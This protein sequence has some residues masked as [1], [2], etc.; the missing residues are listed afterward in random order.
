MLSENPDGLTWRM[1]KILKKAGVAPPE[2]GVDYGKRLKKPSLQGFHALKTSFVTLSLNAGISMEIVQKVVGNTVVEVVREHYF[3]P[4]K[5]SI[6][7]EFQARFPAFLSPRADIDPAALIQS[8]IASVQAMTM[9]NLAPSKAK[10]IEVLERAS[11][12]MLAAS[13]PPAK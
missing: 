2:D 4:S 9:E 13:R 7:A 11:G 3:R 1:M 10:V 6:K 5:E 12:V 8:A